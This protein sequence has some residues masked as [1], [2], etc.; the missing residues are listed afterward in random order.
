MVLTKNIEKMT[1]QLID[2]TRDYGMPLDDYQTLPHAVTAKASDFVGLHAPRHCHPRAQLIYAGSGVM[3]IETDVGCWVIPPLRAVWVPPGITHC[4][5]AL[6][7][8][9]MRTLY[10][11][12]DIAARFGAQCSLVEVGPL[13]RQLILSLCEL[14]TNYDEAGR[15]GLIAQLALQEIRFLGTPAL[16]LPLPASEKLMRVCQQM[17]QQPEAAVTIETLADQLAMSA[18]TL[19]RR[20][21]KET[22]LSFRQWRQQ[23]RLI[24]A[25]AR[26]ASQQPVAQVADALGYAS[27]SA[28]T[29]M[30]R[31]TLGV[32]PS[33][34]FVS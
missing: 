6:G 22:G 1:N 23:A 13:L 19:A 2:H 11:R 8:V 29:A 25:L 24:E 20:F 9:E 32:E 31:R 21:E 10:I 34:Y 12:A 3:R 4:V 18:R 15:G 14:P 16:H 33:R 26:L 7:K 5:D 28:F 17:I 30:F 27:A